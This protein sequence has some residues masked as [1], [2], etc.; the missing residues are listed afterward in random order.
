[1]LKKK[2]STF[3]LSV[4]FCYSTYAKQTLEVIWGDLVIDDPLIEELI[5]SSAMQRIKSVDQS[6]PQ[7]Y[8]GLLPY[9]NRYDHSIGV[10]A[11]LTKA[12]VS[13]N[14]RI[15][16]LLHDVSH[17]VFSHLGDNLFYKD[18]QNKSYQ[19]TIHLRFLKI[20]GIG[21]IVKTR[22]LSIDQL[23]PDSSKYLSLE[24]PLPSLCADRI[25]Y[26][27]HTGVILGNI[28]KSKAK[29][30]VDNLQFVDNKWFFTDQVIAKKFASLSLFFTKN[31]WGAPWNTVF[32]DHFANI[33]QR[34]M[35]LKLITK[36]ELH[37]GIDQD[38]LQKLENSTD[39]SLKKLLS[40]CKEVVKSFSIV[41][42]GKG[43]IN[44]KPKFRGI[45]PLLYYKGQYKKLSEIDSN[46]RKQ[47][48]AVKN[49]CQKG[50]GVNTTPPNNV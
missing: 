1:M 21:N 42:F 25:E 6:G 16:G 20:M 2:F 37:F 33:L 17:T 44:V 41:D 22:G 4:L 12:K 19:D 49:W 9:F 23:N 48:I 26:N 43:R 31:F 46:F 40:S 36:K 18:N 28:S 8:F 3:F 30:M 13:K 15:A 32:Y 10:F 11:L 29:E 27:I 7:P 14:E 24:T 34:A 5:A 45:D 38:I 39:P 47:F 50:Y 35:K